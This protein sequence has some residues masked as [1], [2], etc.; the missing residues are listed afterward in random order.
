MSAE[1]RPHHTTARSPGED[2]AGRLVEAIAHRVNNLLCSV[3]GAGYLLRHAPG[4]SREELLE[5]MEGEVQ[6]LN[7][8]VTKLGLLVDRADRPSV[9]THA[10][11]LVRIAAH[12]VAHS[13]WTCDYEWS[14]PL[15]PIRVR[16]DR[17]AIVVQALVQNAMDATPDGGRIVVAGRNVHVEE[18]RGALVPGDYV[19]I[20]IAD[21]GPGIAPL[22]A[23][24]LLEP[25]VS[26]RDNA[27][28]IGLAFCR[29]VALLHGGDVSVQSPPGAGT[30]ANICLPAARD[31]DE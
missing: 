10:E 31:A 29:T 4:F 16:E 21:D 25:G 14:E 6:M 7:A 24:R 17:L 12:F 9:V 8:A 22:V 20:C 26:T 13:P 2:V 18:H 23:A 27:N 19:E 28:G 30:R 11:N 15:W 3:M 1:P 5:R